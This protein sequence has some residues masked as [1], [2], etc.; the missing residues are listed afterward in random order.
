MVTVVRVTR[1]IKRKLIKFKN[2]LLRYISVFAIR[3]G[4]IQSPSLSLA[5]EDP[6][7]FDATVDEHSTTWM[8][9]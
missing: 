5:G 3:R 9:R 1:T 6:S 7:D 2:V 4:W 8:R